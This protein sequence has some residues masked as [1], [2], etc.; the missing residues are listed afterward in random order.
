[1]SGKQGKSALRPTQ[2]IL[3]PE[4]ALT[5]PTIWSLSDALWD[6]IAIV[7]AELDPPK[8]RGWKRSH[9]RAI[10][11]T[12]CF[13]LRT[14]CQWNHLLR[15][16]PDDSTVHRTFQRWV[17]LGVTLLQFCRVSEGWKMRLTG[18]LL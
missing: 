18:I 12:I 5:L 15:E 6:K 10:F 14:G 17:S 3:I 8:R 11:N 7:L 9:P 4:K 2:D 13:R 16:F 1:M